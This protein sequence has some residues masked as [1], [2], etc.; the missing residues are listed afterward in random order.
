M[1]EIIKSLYFCYISIFFRVFFESLKTRCVLH[2][3]IYN[4]Q[5]ITINVQQIIKIKHNF[6]KQVYALY[7]VDWQFSY[8][9]IL[10]FD[11]RRR[12]T[13]QVS[14][15]LYLYLNGKYELYFQNKFKMNLSYTSTSMKYWPSLTSW[16]LCQRFIFLS[17]KKHQNI[18]VI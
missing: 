18:D 12:W 13:H 14:S 15:G 4:T 5:L 10:A 3:I 8:M 11:I 9:D 1:Q 7:F 2:I 6:L 16:R 17:L